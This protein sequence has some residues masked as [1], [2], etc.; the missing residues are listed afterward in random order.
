MSEDVRKEI[1]RL[2][3]VII[4]T[5]SEVL[6]AINAEMEKTTNEDYLEQWQADVVKMDNILKIVGYIKHSVDNDKIDE[7]T[8]FTLVYASGKLRE[9]L[10][11]IPTRKDLNNKIT[12]TFKEIHRMI[13]PMLFQS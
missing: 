6:L 8:E 2:L 1:H 10:E 5:C 11:K 3:E 13:I 4:A 12:A 9:E 7:C